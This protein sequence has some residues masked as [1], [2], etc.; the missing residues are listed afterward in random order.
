[1]LEEAPCCQR[2][3]LPTHVTG[4]QIGSEGIVSVNGKFPYG[5]SAEQALSV[6]L[7]VFVGGAALKPNHNAFMHHLDANQEASQD[8]E[9]SAAFAWSDCIGI[10]KQSGP[11]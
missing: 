11:G 3:L 1:M 5:N 2:R 7:P 6:Y 4:A 9:Y 10:R 8:T